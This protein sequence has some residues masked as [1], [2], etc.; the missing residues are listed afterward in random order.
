MISTRFFADLKR[1]NV[2]LSADGDHL[3][4]RAPRGVL[5][6]RLQSQ[7]ALCK[8]DLLAM[9]KEDGGK[10]RLSAPHQI[11]PDP[12][13]KH[14]PFPLTDIQQAYFVGRKRAFELGNVACH[15]YYEVEA[16]SLDVAKFNQALQALIERHDM[17]RA[18]V[19]ADGRQQI[20]RDVP[21][22]RIKVVDLRGRG[23]EEV[24]AVLDAIRDRM[25]H[26]VLAAD[27]WPLFEVRASRLED[28]LTRLH[29]SF[30]MLIADALSL[31][32]LFREWAA[33][34]RDSGRALS[35][36]E[37][38]F[39]DYA[40]AE[41]GMRDSEAYRRAE[42]Y[43]AARLPDLPVG[44]ELPLAVSPSS[45]KSPRF[46]RR[47]H[48]LEP[49]SWSRIKDRAQ[50]RGL[51]PS[52]VLLAAYAEVLAAWSKKPRFTINVTL[53]NRQP[54]HRL[55]NSLVGDFTSLIP[56]AVDHSSSDSFEARAERIRSQLLEDMEHRCY[57]GVRVLR[58]LARAQGRSATTT[59][60]VV[61]TSLLSHHTAG[62]E[63][64]Q[65]LWMGD[66]IYGISQTPQVWLD[67][68]VL[69]EAGALVFNWDAVEEL[70]P[71]DL[72]RE[73]FDSYCALL[74]RLADDEGLW[75]E[76]VRGLTPPAHLRQR[77]AVNATGSPMPK[78]MLHTL[79]AEQANERPLQTAV[80][81][82]RVRLT[83]E[84]LYRVASNL[85]REVREAGG[86]P[87]ALVAVVM[88]KGWE[89]VAAALAILQS[90]AAYLP[91]DP[92]L[93]AERLR[94]LLE[95]AGVTTA[96]TEPRLDESLSWPGHVR[97]ITVGPDQ[98]NAPYAGWLE[99]VQTRDDLA[100]VIY[101]SGST[102]LPKG[103][104]INHA[105][106]V[107]TI[108]DINR[109]FGVGPDDKV[110]ALSS[111][112]FDLSVY[113]IFGTLAAGGTIVI[114]D[115]SATRDPAQ[116]ARLIEQESVTVWNSVPALMEMLTAY[117]DGRGARLPDCLRLVLLSGDWIPVTL[118]DKIKGL[119]GN[120]RVISL[121]GATE[122]SIW[123]ILYPIDSLAPG[124]KSVPYG[125]PML[126]QRFHVLND[127]FDPCPNWVPGHLYIAG[128]GLALGYWRDEEK[129][130]ASFINHPHT[131]E[132]LYKTGDLG[133]YLPDG[134]I[135]FLGREDS[136]VKVQGY[137]IELGEIETTL[138]LY[139]GVR[140]A[141]VKAAGRTRENKRLIC[142]VAADGARVPTAE[143]LRGFLREKL[144]AYMIPSSF[145]VLDS[146]PLTANGKVDRKALPDPAAASQKPVE[147]LSAAAC[148][149]EERI[150]ACV[151]D[152]LGIDRPEMS[153]SLL[154]LGAN[155]VD[156]IRI[157]GL[158]E[159]EFG[160]APQFE[161][162]YST[163]T[164][165]DLA[166]SYRERLSSGLASGES[167]VP[168][169]GLPWTPSR[170]ILDP[171]EREQFKKRQPGIRRL[172]EGSLQ[173]E[174]TSGETDEAL[175]EKYVARR[176]RRRFGE[177]PVTL[178][179]LGGLIGLLRQVTVGGEPRHLYASAGGLY[180]VQVYL[181]IKRGRVEGAQPGVY[182]Y[183][184][185]DNRLALISPAAE[186]DRSIHEPFINAP[187]FDGAA[188]SIFLIAQLNAITPIYGGRGL[189]FATIEAGLITQLLEMSCS[190]NG[191]GLCQVGAIDFER[192][193]HLFALDD[194]HMLIHSMVGGPSG[195]DGREQWAPVQE[196][197]YQPAGLM[198]S[199]QK[200]EL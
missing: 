129:T 116:W 1:Q 122:A 78:A 27:K 155:S 126:N 104:M 190:A 132:R 82:G 169:A 117:A 51:T 24:R 134:N 176:S 184:P 43:W 168:G 183:H 167:S 60:P 139:P 112:S 48:R 2:H 159:K 173:I 98:L 179:Q 172:T 157:A 75:R 149:A 103:V 197:P 96:L 119:A 141:A 195:V 13:R 178:G 72:L 107:N 180:P 20:L 188:F 83:Y 115:A 42:Q 105:G 69:E 7:I 120:A 131:G 86:R 133:R 46:V 123:S 92:K 62:Q 193:R 44:P 55:V 57:G 12:A 199:C 80:V 182:Y 49:Q 142:Y 160:F 170:P 77:A 58:D 71:Q 68:Q 191:I 18:I 14:E 16:K 19:L 74:D 39:K 38:S 22:Y 127:A 41:A 194:S 11:A 151:A 81:A 156:I 26:Q 45:V 4:V 89:Q 147:S 145:V 136:Q 65:T 144:P 84:D 181:H 175:A 64:D 150:S 31:Q 130:R 186:L 99:P 87:G 111:L 30:D 102:G 154:E 113:D 200:G 66:V 10:D 146:L 61:F 114:P 6:E 153:A 192:I 3:R 124:S 161:E 52:G 53:L 33:L 85:G 94:H 8:A 79:F 165:K 177:R 143:G 187:L 162:L 95:H 90:G 101:T 29:F 25:S 135:E 108:I 118:P 109:R 50:T 138:E 171:D 88:E 67:H 34:Y 93:P 35:P 40:A 163:P 152:V 17:L 28:D 189:H 140:K 63:S 47:S 97:R 164:I 36:L 121:G 148:S 198:G 91:V 32:I 59:I 56:L 21:D 15:T 166:A 76:Q 185:A 9:L 158:L 174:L 137:R 128:A 196:V 5:T 100:Y 70:F 23:V 106:A 125:R 110:L 54:F 37:V 73:M